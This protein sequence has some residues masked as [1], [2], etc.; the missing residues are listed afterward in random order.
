MADRPEN[1]L[2]FPGI[3]AILNAMQEQEPLWLPV[4]RLDF[5]DSC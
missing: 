4:T 2:L 1:S 3:P 5:Q